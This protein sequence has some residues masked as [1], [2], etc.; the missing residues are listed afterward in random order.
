MGFFLPRMWLGRRRAGRLER[1][2]QAASRHDHSDRQLSASR[3]VVP[4]G[5]RD[6]RPG[7]ATADHR[8]V[9]PRRPGGQPRPR[10][11]R[12]A[13]EHGPPRSIRRPRVDG[14]RNHD[15]APGRR[16]PRRDPGLD[17]IHDSRTCP[18]QGRDP[19]ADRPTADVG[20]RRRR[21][22][23]RARGDP[24]RNRPYVHAADVRKPTGRPRDC[25]PGS[26]SSWSAASSCSSGSS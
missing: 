26:F 8:G 18:D 16:Q 11:R 20:L 17:R 7:S 19:D 3:V 1:V 25:R 10:L 4:P 13:G 2:Q 23:D 6:G 21:H 12:R 5:H 9:R 24:V 15:S 14:D 22:A